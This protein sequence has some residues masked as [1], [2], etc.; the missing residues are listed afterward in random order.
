[1]INFTSTEINIE[2]FFPIHP[3][4]S[5]SIYILDREISICFITSRISNYFVFIVITIIAILYIVSQSNAQA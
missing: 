1:M 4:L 5:V 2:Q 3:F